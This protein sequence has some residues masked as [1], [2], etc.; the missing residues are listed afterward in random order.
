SAASGNSATASTPSV[1]SLAIGNHI[2]TVDYS[3]D[4]NFAASTD[5]AMTGNPQVVNP[6]PTFSINN[7][8]IV[9]P[10]SGTATMLFTVTLATPA[11]ST[12]TV[13]YSTADGSAVAGTD[14]VAVP[15][16]ILTF[17][18]GDQVKTIPVTI[19]G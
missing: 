15:D 10:S 19:N 11:T 8:S 18:T 12:T 3:G 5:N 7:A 13:H 6:A 9:K 14:Y 4:A 17:K 16:T 1:T 2:I